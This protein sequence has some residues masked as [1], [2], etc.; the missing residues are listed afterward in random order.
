MWNITFKGISGDVHI[1]EN[2]DRIA[3]YSLLDMDPRTNSFEVC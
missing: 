1:D 3:D 2:G